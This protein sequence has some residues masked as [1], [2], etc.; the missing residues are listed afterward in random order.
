[1]SVRQMEQHD[2]SRAFPSMSA[3]ELAALEAD[4]QANGLI[5]PV[6]VYEG[7][8]LDG[9]HRYMACQR[10]G[11]KLLTQ[12]YSGKDPVGFVKSRNWHRRHLTASQKAAAEVAMHDWHERGRN[13]APGADLKTAEQMAKDAGVSTRTIE[14]AKAAHD[15]GLGKAVTDGK[16]S[17]KK[18]AAVAKLPAPQREQAVK[19][20][21]R[22]EKPALPKASKGK[23]FEAL[24]E[25][26]MA[27]VESL[28][29]RLAEVTE[30]VER[31]SAVEQGEEATLIKNL[32]AELRAMKQKRDDVMRENV[33]LRKQLKI[34]QRKAG[35]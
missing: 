11:V 6:M 7:K 30:E 10:T 23:N 9:W 16:V 13:S 33:E 4:I 8:I 22:G 3:E 14:Q 19:A 20:I 17:V 35:K 31:L 34:A 5:E 27:D 2:L 18:A 1:M 21:E 29:E 15:A 24:Y 12:P 25:S 28:R 26:A 32:Q